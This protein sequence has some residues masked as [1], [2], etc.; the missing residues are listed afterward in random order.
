MC[1]AQLSGF[2][3]SVPAPNLLTPR[4]PRD[5]LLGSGNIRAQVLLM[6]L[7]LLGS[8]PFR[9]GA[10]ADIRFWGTH[11]AKQDAHKRP[12]VG[13]GGVSQHPFFPAISLFGPGG[14]DPPWTR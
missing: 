3:P 10:E 5:R 12:M 8:I 13:G 6:L 9:K 1:D 7:L 2:D 11:G 14:L 4:V